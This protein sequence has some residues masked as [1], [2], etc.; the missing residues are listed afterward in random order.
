MILSLTEFEA[1]VLGKLVR[2]ASTFLAEISPVPDP[3]DNLYDRTELLARLNQE[4]YAMDNVREK[5][6]A[7]AMKE[8][9][10]RKRGTQPVGAA[11]GS[12]PKTPANMPVAQKLPA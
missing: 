12:T 5:I 9:R 2:G 6:R 4:R 10:R 8:S 3:T 11:S 7:M 1:K